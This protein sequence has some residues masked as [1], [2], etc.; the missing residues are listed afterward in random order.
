MTN[1]NLKGTISSE[2]LE[3]KAK[4]N[5]LEIKGQMAVGARGKSAYEIWLEQGNTGTI[6][7]FLNAI[8][9][10]KQYTH[11][12]MQPSL[13]WTIVHNLGKYPSVAIVDSGDNVVYA[14]VEYVSENT[15]I[16]NFSAEHSGKAY[17][18]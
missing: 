6:T 12:Q 13:S 2:S 3:I 5:T 18:N 8:G 11:W 17:L 7:D 4:I 15:L 9:G 10:D 16:I 1:N 14:D